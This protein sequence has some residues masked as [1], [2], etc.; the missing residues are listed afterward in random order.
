VT[1][2][3]QYLDRVERMSQT[4]VLLSF[5]LPAALSALLFNLPQLL[6]HLGVGA[7]PWVK[8]YT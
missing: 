1:S 2:S 5:L 8:R 3:Y 7:D 4:S 6:P